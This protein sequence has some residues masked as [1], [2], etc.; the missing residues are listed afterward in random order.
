MDYI[1]VLVA[2]YLMRVIPDTSISFLKTIPGTPSLTFGNLSFTQ[3]FDV[4]YTLVT[5]VSW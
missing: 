3:T 1:K 2:I 4:L 5:C